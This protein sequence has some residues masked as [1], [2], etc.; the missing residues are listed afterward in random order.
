MCA[1]HRIRMPCEMAI[2]INFSLVIERNRQRPHQ[3][4]GWWARRHSRAVRP[5]LTSKSTSTLNLNNDTV[6]LASS[7]WLPPPYFP[8]E[9]LSDSLLDEYP[10]VP[11]YHSS[12]SRIMDSMCQPR[13][14][15][16]ADGME[17]EQI[18]PDTQDHSHVA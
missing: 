7:V 4:Q 18:V 12:G 8:T 6:T 2:S 1:T 16:A 13:Q 9:P 3:R 14:V 5:W 10:P 15:E 11:P 17:V